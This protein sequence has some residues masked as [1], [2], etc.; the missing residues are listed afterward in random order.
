[1]AFGQFLADFGQFLGDF[2]VNLGQ[3]L[4]N[5]IVPTGEQWSDIQH[6]YEQMGDTISSHIPFVS[7]FSDELKKAQETVAK[8]DF[9]VITVPSFSFSSGGV[10]VTTDEQK[11]INV[12]QAYEPYRAYVRGA[13]L[14]IVVRT[15][16]CIYHKICFGTWSK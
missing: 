3:F 4:I 11:V 12:G 1:M 9:L 6:D 2:F 14:M 15:C 5:L 10:G 13:L 8:T 7:L 16:F